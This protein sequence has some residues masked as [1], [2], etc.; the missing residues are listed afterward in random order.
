MCVLCCQRGSSVAFCD[1]R[2]EHY[3]NDFTDPDLW[4]Q[5]CLLS[6]P[7]RTVEVVEVTNIF[8]LCQLLCQEGVNCNVVYMGGLSM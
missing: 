5:C 7:Q 3:C 1:E 6:T 4:E 8:L 2:K